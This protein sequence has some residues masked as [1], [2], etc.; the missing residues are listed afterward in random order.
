MYK[1]QRSNNF[2]DSLVKCKQ[3]GSTF[4]TMDEVVKIEKNKTIPHPKD[5]SAKHELYKVDSLTVKPMSTNLR[6]LFNV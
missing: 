4:T 3:H 1:K 5:A 6:C 2:E